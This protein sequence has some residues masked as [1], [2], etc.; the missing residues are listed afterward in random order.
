M[1]G[2]FLKNQLEPCPN[3]FKNLLLRLHEPSKTLGSSIISNSSGQFFLIWKT[4]PP[5][6]IVTLTIHCVGAQTNLQGESCLAVHRRGP[7]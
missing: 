3:P 6:S 2:S 4:T 1:P 5:S 7:L